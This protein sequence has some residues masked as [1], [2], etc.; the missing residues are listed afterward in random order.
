MYVYIETIYNPSFPKYI[1]LHS[2]CF[3][4]FA[5]YAI[6][7]DVIF[8]VFFLHSRA[9]EYVFVTVL[10]FV[11]KKLKKDQATNKFRCT[12]RVINNRKN[13]KTKTK[14]RISL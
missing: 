9:S 13:Q 8:V 5:I 12:R 10:H 11:P 1:S 14:K 2:I 4:V 6:S 7:F 3:F